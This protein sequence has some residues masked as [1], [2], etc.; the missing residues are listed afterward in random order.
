MGFYAAKVKLSYEFARA[1]PTDNPKYQDYVSF[2]KLFGDD[3]NLMVIGVQTKHFFEKEHFSHY[4]QFG[5]EVKHV[6]HVEEVLSV[7]MAVIL[8]KDSIVEKLLKATTV[9]CV[10]RVNRES[11]PL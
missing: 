11:A 10:R 4:Q 6:P 9:P 7:P 2:K 8:E 5:N 1:I 3:G